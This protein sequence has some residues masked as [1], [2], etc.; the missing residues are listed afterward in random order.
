MTPECARD[1]LSLYIFDGSEN[2]KE[3]QIRGPAAKS[4]K[5]ERKLTFM[6]RAT[7]F[8]PKNFIIISKN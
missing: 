5:N 3:S 8:C 1:A 7:G 6:K 4:D 2:R